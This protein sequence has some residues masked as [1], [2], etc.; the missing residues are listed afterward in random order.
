MRGVREHPA[1]P[2]VSNLGSQG[3]PA[4]RAGLNAGQEA[5][6]LSA[7][8]KEVARELRGIREDLAGRRTGGPPGV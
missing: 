8:L 1:R 6:P 2:G 7:T 4:A 5:D 3:E